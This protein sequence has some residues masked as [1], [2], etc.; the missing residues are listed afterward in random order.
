MHWMPQL[1]LPTWSFGNLSQV[2]NDPSWKSRR[3]QSSW[4][5][6]GHDDVQPAIWLT[7][8]ATI[9]QS[10]IHLGEFFC[11]S[12]SHLFEIHSSI[13]ENAQN[14]TWNPLLWSSHCIRTAVVFRPLFL[15]LSGAIKIPHS[16]TE[17]KKSEMWFTNEICKDLAVE[18][19]PKLLWKFSTCKWKSS[20]GFPKC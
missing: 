2:F 13:H 7:R 3:T 9:E 8:A 15:S 18:L 12:P 10:I 1:R 5:I 19:N 16:R 11:S 14:P 20:K 4:N 6:L 17:T